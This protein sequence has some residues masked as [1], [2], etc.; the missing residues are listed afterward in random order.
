MHE[1]ERPGMVETDL[2]EPYGSAAALLSDL[3]EQIEMFEKSTILPPNIGTVL[4]DLRKRVAAAG[5]LV[6]LAATGASGAETPKLCLVLS[7]AKIP[8]I[9]GA[10][11]E[12][13][14]GDMLADR[15]S[16]P[17][18]AKVQVKTKIANVEATFYFRCTW[19]DRGTDVA[20][21]GI[22]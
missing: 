10:V 16:G 14:S 1:L 19:D 22:R 20:S 21:E 9:P 13:I 5:L 11:I 15:G 7:A 12:S 3:D 2:P 18:Y 17:G 8:P 6:M 4:A